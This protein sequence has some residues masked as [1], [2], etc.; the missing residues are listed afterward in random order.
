MWL[1]LLIG[2]PFVLFALLGAFDS[3]RRLRG[4]R[5]VVGTLGG[6]LLATGGGAFFSIALSSLGGIPTTFEW[7]VGYSNQIIKLPNGLQVA[8]HTPSGRMQVY[9]QDWRFQRAW[10]VDASG[11]TFKARLTET[12]LLEVWTARGQ[13]RFLFDSQ[14][15]LVDSGSYAPASYSSLQESG[16]AGYVPTTF[17]LWILAHP[18]VA[19]AVGLV[20][21]LMLVSSDRRRMQSKCGAKQS[22]ALSS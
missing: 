15:G 9:D 19:W 4:I 22:P 6:I 7:P 1:V 20:G 18:F 13:M 12:G 8:T 21:L 5:R 2:V 11:G 17:F 10:S 3:W 16:T 14:G